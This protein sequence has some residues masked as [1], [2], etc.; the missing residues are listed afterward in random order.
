MDSQVEEVKSRV[1]IVALISE[2]LPLKKA[3]R[4][5]KGLCPFHSEKTPSFMVNPDR[6]IFKCF[7]CGEGGDAFSFLKRMEGMEFGEALQVLA[8]KSGVALRQY[9]PSPQELRKETLFKI[10]Q[11]AAKMYSYLLTKHPSGK[12]ALEYL[13]ARG[14]GQKSIKDFEL[15]VAPNQK[16]FICQFLLKRGFSKSDLVASGLA[17]QTSDGLI[18]R[19]RGRVIFPVKDAQSRV[20]G[21]SGRALGNIE[22]KYLNSPE[23]PIFNKSNVLY[24]IDLA[25]SQMKKEK[26]AVLVEGNLDVIS[27]H[28]VGVVNTVAPLG[29]ALTES[30]IEVL[31]RYSENLLFAFDTDLAGDAAGKRGIGIAENAGLNIRVVQIAEGKDPDEMIR[32][33]PLLWKKA[34]KEAV[35]I[36]DY[37]IAS[38]LKKY[39]IAS[40]EGKRKAALEVLPELAKL[41]DEILLGHYLQSLASK[42]GLEEESLREVLLRLVEKTENREEGAIKEI[43]EKPLTGNVGMLIEK[44]LL[45]LVLQTGQWSNE[46]S[47]ELFREVQNKEIFS[48]LKKA[49]AEKGQ[50]K[51]KKITSSL[52]EALLPVLDE[53]LLTE[54]DDE[55]LDDKNR[56]GKEISYCVRRLKELNLRKKLKEVSLAIKQAQAAGNQAKIASLSEEFGKLTKVLTSV[57]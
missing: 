31:K 41:K 4:N 2:Y 39:D 42:I 54:I 30:Q 27:S 7:G 52:P 50:I 44:Y 49:Y 17:I 43:L 36:Y 48:L 34:I 55:L 20:L 40:A 45:A 37:F 23:T 57:E 12:R 46:I 51:V 28:Q 21:F 33:N 14:V 24:G 29:T 19:F 22:P 5:Y 3:G 56:S 18:D 26:S 13:K 32:K 47:Q 8:K 6:Q 15:G 10:S 16:G 11:L 38:A 9:K 25:R 1:D 53:L 35:P